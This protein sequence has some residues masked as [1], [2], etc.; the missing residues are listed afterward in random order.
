MCLEDQ[1]EVSRIGCLAAPV[2]AREVFKY[3]TTYVK[4]R[5]YSGTFFFFLAFAGKV[6]ICIGLSGVMTFTV[7]L[8]SIPLR[9]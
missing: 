6:L 7:I 1:S 2:L 4:E 9:H 3:P 5:T 8:M